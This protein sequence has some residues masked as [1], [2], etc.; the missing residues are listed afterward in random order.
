MYKFPFQQRSSFMF[1][2]DKF[3]GLKDTD[4]ITLHLNEL[5]QENGFKLCIIIKEFKCNHNRNVQSLSRNVVFN[6]GDSLQQAGTK[7]QTMKQKKNRSQNNTK[8]SK[9]FF[10]DH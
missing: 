2:P 3:S 8:D 7:V 9:T 5:C 4:K 1:D 6:D 10:I